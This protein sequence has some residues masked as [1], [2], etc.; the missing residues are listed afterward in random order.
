LAVQLK[1]FFM[2]DP[3]NTAALFTW[4]GTTYAADLNA[5]IVIPVAA[6]EDAK[7]HGFYQQSLT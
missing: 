2:A 5:E 7:S 4:D 6:S 1:L 3:T